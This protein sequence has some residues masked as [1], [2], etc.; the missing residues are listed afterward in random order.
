VPDSALV[1]RAFIRGQGKAAIDDDE[2]PG[3]AKE[4]DVPVE[5]RFPQAAVHLPSLT[6]RVIDDELSLGLLDLDESSELRG[7]G[8]FALP[9]DVGGGLEQTDDP[10]GIVRIAAEH[11]APVCATTCR[12]RSTVMDS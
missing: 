3:T 5:R 1:R 6:H 12:T 9:D 2:L 4:P 7:L 11:A 8:Q 10:A